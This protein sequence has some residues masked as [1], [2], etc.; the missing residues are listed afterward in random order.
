MKS[1]AI[2]CYI[3]FSFVLG[4]YS[5]HLCNADDQ[6]NIFFQDAENR[7]KFSFMNEQILEEIILRRS[8][9]GSSEVHVIPT[10]V[11]IIHNNGD[12]NISSTQVDNAILWLNEAYSNSGESYNP[13]GIQVPV[14]FCLAKEDPN[15]EFTEGVNYV[16]NS[17]TDMLVP[18]Q[19]LALKN[20]IRWNPLEYLNIWVVKSVTREDDSPGVVG[21]STFPDSHGSELDGIVIEAEYF[22]FTQT[23]NNVVAHESGHYLG[24]F[25][26]FQGGCPN[27]DCLTTGDMVCDTPP[28]QNLFN[29]L[30]FDGTNSC[31]TDEDDT[32][33]NNPFRAEGLGGLGDQVDQQTN[34]M[35]YSSVL[36]F[37]IFTAGQSERMTAALGLRS[38]LLDDDKC[39]PPCANPIVANISASQSVIDVGETIA[40]TNLSSN[41]TA[42]QWYV[43]QLPVSTNESFDFTP[44][45]QGDYVIE[46][47]L[48]NETP[49]CYQLLT[50]PVQVNCPLTVDISPSST[51]ISEGGTV[52]FT[53]STTGAS[54]FE[55]FLNNVSVG[56]AEQFSY[57]FDEVGI[58]SVYMVASNGLCEVTS[59]V[60]N[61]SVGS[62]TSGNEH[63]IWHWFNPSGNGF[64][65]D[66]N[67]QPVS[68]VPEDP[69]LSSGHCKAT[70]C[71]DAGNL[72]F[73]S[74]GVAVY[75]RNYD[76]VE[77][78]SGL[79]GDESSHFGTM[80][81]KVPGDESKYYLF[82]TDANP[83]FT[84]GLRYS[85]IDSE[86]NSGLG[87]VTDVKNEFLETTNNE[88]I[89][90]VKHCNLNHRWL[91]FY[92][93]PEGKMKSYLITE[94]GI[95]LEPVVTQLDLELS[96]AAYGTAL[97][98]SP[99]G[100]KLVYEKHLM[101][102]NQSTG[103]IDNVVDMGTEFP[104]DNVV[105]SHDF[106]P[107]GKVLY[108]LTGG[109]FDINLFQYDLTLPD[110]L[111]PFP[112]NSV[113]SDIQLYSKDMQKGKDDVIYMDQILPGTLATIS[114]PNLLG[115]AMDFQQD[116]IFASAFINGFG[117]FYHAYIAGQDIIID[118]NEIICAGMDQEFS[119]FGSDCIEGD[120][121]WEF[122]GAGQFIVNPNQ[123]VS[124][125][126]PN[127]GEATLI[128][129]TASNCG[130]ITD[131]LHISIIQAPEFDLGPDV[132][133]CSSEPTIT[134]EMPSEFEYYLWSTGS[135]EQSISLTNPEP[136]MI[137]ARGYYQG[138]YITDEIEIIGQID[139]TIDLG[140]D[141]T[142]CDGVVIVLDAGVGFTD[143]VWQDGSIG[144]TYTVFLGGSYSVSASGPCAASDM[145][146]IDECDQTIN[147]VENNSLID[148]F[149]VYPNPTSD[150]FVVEFRAASSERLTVEIVDAL[151][152]TVYSEIC[153]VLNGNN[154]L[155]LSVKDFP[156]GDY[157]CRIEGVSVTWN[158]KIV[159]FK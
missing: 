121:D 58:S 70:I 116:D 65:F 35:D 1:L 69:M 152:R 54:S 36:C 72:L 135:L 21:Y 151:G 97:K 101:D 11:H 68:L 3:S 38:S 117:N 53:V 22:G 32:S 37:D 145:I 103:T 26:T 19:D 93:I 108:L 44:E 106:S 140:V 127:A 156:A 23:L 30:C 129:K 133:F 6:H 84:D 87:L 119:V 83:S 39:S 10:V 82:T 126:F 47:E 149:T 80:F 62:C 49:G 4:S 90:I 76:I 20:L 2:L 41:Y 111:K 157:I 7:A 94:T 96:S 61:I 128:A 124:G 28:D 107:S 98:V 85:I 134:L 60:W 59:Q 55:W 29:L 66:F 137:E 73:V 155:T 131:T 139:E 130:E 110:E 81:L 52:D 86:E 88:H 102:F 48:N 120:I 12:E 109:V 112:T 92:D 114:N 8:G 78:G 64:G 159:V 123:T 40:Y 45:V 67:D 63:N 14:Q 150:Y 105:I 50:L 18:S 34:Y 27:D 138:C 71:D 142:L 5:Q 100:D 56:D 25:H 89:N 143:Y 77:N 42:I 148:L 99:Q 147:S 91:I 24:L 51:A 113:F 125:F 154:Q 115:D 136:Q 46:L 9:G 33:E 144:Q 13:D 104:L 158:E 95:S 122:S 146:I 141:Q 31:L 17:L 74:N 118:G 75:D 153:N 132:G 43:N 15:G 79:L 16:Q 57:A